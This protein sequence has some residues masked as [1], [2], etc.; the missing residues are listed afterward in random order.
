MI[1]NIDTVLSESDKLLITDMK[2]SQLST[3]AIRQMFFCTKDK[4]LNDHQIQ[5]INKCFQKSQIREQNV[6]EGLSDADRLIAFLKKEPSISF[7]LLYDTSSSTLIGGRPKGIPNRNEV[8]FTT[9]TYHN[10]GKEVFIGVA[11]VTDQERRLFQKFPE[12]SFVDTTS[13]TNNELCP[14][15]MMCGKDST[16]MPFAALRFIMPSEQRWSF[17]RFYEIATPVL[18]GSKACSR[19]LLGI[20]DG[21]ANE[22]LS[23]ESSIGKHYP[24]SQHLLCRWH[25]ITHITNKLRLTAKGHPIGG[26]TFKLLNCVSPHP[27]LKKPESM[28]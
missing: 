1:H 28:Y 8:T 13:Q 16:S 7:I 20:T 10:N 19:N 15:L 27:G 2:G 12:V 25:L 26:P 11:W 22:Y 6:Q 17:K 21:D 5:W 24:N 9:K 18:L 23:F 14:L 4:T 3:M